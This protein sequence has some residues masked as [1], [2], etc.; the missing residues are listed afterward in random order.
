MYKVGLIGLNNLENQR[1]VGDGGNIIYEIK[2]YDIGKNGPGIF[3]ESTFGDG[4]KILVQL[5]ESSCC[6]IWEISESHNIL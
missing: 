5:M 2:L 4:Q 3:N 1:V 6:W